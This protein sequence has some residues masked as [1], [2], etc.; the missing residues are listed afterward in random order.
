MLVAIVMSLTGLGHRYFASK[1]T[2][3]PESLSQQQFAAYEAH[4]PVLCAARVAWS[5]ALLMFYLRLLVVIT[6]NPTLGP[7]L[8][9]M[10]H[11]VVRDLLP[12]L[13]TST[14]RQARAPRRSASRRRLEEA[15]IQVKLRA[16]GGDGFIAQR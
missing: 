9:M 14:R 2:S 13:G 6:I 12:L 4:D 7:R 8:T 1:N 16:I 11:M 15:G 10:S 5:C 3:S